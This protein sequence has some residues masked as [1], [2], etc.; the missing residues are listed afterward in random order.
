M[1]QTGQARY[2]FV[3]LDIDKADFAKTAPQ[4]TW[5][6]ASGIWSESH[7]LQLPESGHGRAGP[8]VFDHEVVDHVAAAGRHA[9]ERIFHETRHFAAGDTA[10]R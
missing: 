8:V 5:R 2:H 6:D 7:V 9:V 3:F 4:P 10:D 1:Y